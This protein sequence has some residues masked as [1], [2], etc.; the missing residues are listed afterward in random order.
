MRCKTRV[1][2]PDD[3]PE[4]ARLMLGA[5]APVSDRHGRVAHCGRSIGSKLIRWIA[6]SWSTKEAELAGL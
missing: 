3:S 6:R 1:I 5:E 4:G 2:F